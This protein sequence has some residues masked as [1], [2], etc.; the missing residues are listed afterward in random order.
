MSVGSIVGKALALGGDDVILNMTKKYTAK[1][2]GLGHVITGGVTAAMAINQ[3]GEERESGKG[4]L[5]AAT[6][7]VV[8]NAL[9]FLMGFGAYAVG[10]VAMNAPGAIMGGME[11]VNTM[12]RG[13]AQQSRNIPFNN[14]TFVDT[15]QAYTMRQ[16]GMQLAQR[17]K[18][19]VQQTMLGNEAR[20]LHR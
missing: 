3:Y 20:G 1:F 5:G 9:P 14:S 7:A 13:M 2:G 15:E 10:A 11:K 8:D 19:N 12:A 18:Y 16:A 17:S 4:V 6:S